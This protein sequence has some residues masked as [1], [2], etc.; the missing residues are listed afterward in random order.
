MET[1]ILFSH[2][3][4]GK[5]CICSGSKCNLFHCF[6]IAQFCVVGKAGK[7]STFWLKNDISTT[8]SISVTSFI[9]IS[10]MSFQGIFTIVKETSS[11]GVYLVQGEVLHIL[12]FLPIFSM[13]F[14]GLSG[15]LFYSHNVFKCWEV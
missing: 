6:N 8:I 4:K 9:R 14:F 3:N 11:L 2:I 7:L 13:L 1:C 12:L 5:N 10:H 15:V